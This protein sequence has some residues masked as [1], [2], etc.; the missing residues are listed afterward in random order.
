M[1]KLYFFRNKASWGRNIASR[2]THTWKSC[3]PGILFFY[4]FYRTILSEIERENER[5]ILHYCAIFCPYYVIFF[6]SPFSFFFSPFFLFFFFFFLLF[7]F[8]SLSLSLTALFFVHTALFF[9][10]H[11]TI[12]WSLLHFFHVW[13]FYIPIILNTRGIFLYQKQVFSFFRL[14]TTHFASSLGE[15]GRNF[16][17]FRRQLTQFLKDTVVTNTI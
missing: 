8:F 4:H 5:N 14:A 11:R 6:F 15:S 16:C 13:W 7:S 2:N 12:F 3:H 10:P 1:L 17:V 9:G